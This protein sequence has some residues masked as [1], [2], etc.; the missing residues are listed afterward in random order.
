MKGES[1]IRFTNGG[2][3]VGTITDFDRQNFYVEHVTRIQRHRQLLEFS[4]SGTTA[5]PHRVIAAVKTNG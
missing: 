5:V 1:E 2:R 3:I 4:P